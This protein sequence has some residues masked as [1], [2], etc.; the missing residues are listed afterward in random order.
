VSNIRDHGTNGGAE[1]GA[2]R[3][4][5]PIQWVLPALVCM[6]AALGAVAG[7][8]LAAS[9]P[10]DQHLGLVSG[11]A[12]LVLLAGAGV[13]AWITALHRRLARQ[14]TLHDT[15]MAHMTHGVSVIDKNLTVTAINA[16][17]MELL[18][19]PAEMGPGVPYEQL[20]QFNAERGEYGPGDPEE[21]I[22]ERMDMARLGE[23]I[24]FD[25]VRPN[26]QVLQIRG[27][28]IPGGGFVTIYTD[29]T[30]Q[31][32][33]DDELKAHTAHLQS[34]L[35]NL[36]AR[37]TLRDKGKR[38]VFAN[39]AYAE[40]FSQPAKSFIGKTTEEMFGIA[41]GV[42]VNDL[43]DEVIATG[44]AVR[45]RTFSA[46]RFPGRTFLADV[47]PL[48][49][50]AG[51]PLGFLTSHVDVSELH[52]TQRK[53]REKVE[54]LNTIF[55]NVPLAMSIRDRNA[56]II[57]MNEY[58]AKISGKRPADFVG[59]TLA[60]TL[61]LDGFTEPDKA[62]LQVS[63]TG[64]PVADREIVHT[65]DPSRTSIMRSIPLFDVDGEVDRVLNVMWE[66][67]EL[68]QAEREAT[69]RLNMLQSVIDNIPAVI[70]IRDRDTRALLINETA[71]KA[72]GMSSDEVL[73]K[74]MKE[75][76]G[77]KRNRTSESHVH[78][79]LETGEPVRNLEIPFAFLPGR[80]ALANYVPLFDNAGEVDGVLTV[81]MDITEKKDA[82]DHLRQAGK[83]STLGQMA[84]GMVHELSQPT[85]IIKLSA[86][87]SLLRIKRGKIDQEY[88][89]EQFSRI[90]K[91]A[92]RMGK[93]IDHIR[94]FSRK[95][96]SDF[97]LFDVIELIDR[98][99][100]LFRVQLKSTNIALSCSQIP[101]EV[102]CEGHPFQLEQ[103]LLNLLNNAKDAIEERSADASDAP[104]SGT[105][106]VST[107]IREGSHSVEIVVRDDGGGIPD[108][109]LENI[110]DPFFTTK[111]PGKGTGLGLSV[112]YGIVA[113]M[114][115]RISASRIDGGMVFTV[116]LPCSTTAEASPLSD[117]G[118]AIPADHLR[119]GRGRP[120]LVV[121]DEDE[122]ATMIQEHLMSCGFRVEVAENGIAALRKIE[123]ECPAILLT[124][125]KMP[126]MGGRELAGTV[127]ARFGDIPIIFITG[128]M[129]PLEAP[130]SEEI[131]KTITFL[132]KPVVLGELEDLVFEMIG[133]AAP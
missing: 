77:A 47:I 11:F 108:A 125:I 100:G 111:E 24:E 26:G 115:G 16:K 132:K 66:I 7:E 72:Y 15:M 35:D 65:V 43:V 58:G 55:D 124:D 51:N 23:P 69:A 28:P 63:R 36:P 17:A 96:T 121:D 1:T 131:D 123:R 8:A 128:E 9:S 113:N 119:D 80:I 59:H 70:S 56:R 87:G 44:V 22:R 83:L 29:V 4:T 52:K 129:V 101:S 40:S 117:Q 109:A 97:E 33:A 2:M 90:D 89:T 81:L 127:R 106:D 76:F 126:K 41:E 62:N 98:T 67:T 30:A 27:N 46:P 105:I 49:D 85:S 21:L 48:A 91:Q 68:K 92:S 95:E 6:L 3:R 45:S 34:I 73:G 118:E 116:V 10:L 38:F 130:D 25:R 114:S 94:L 5:R 74:T 78:H 107:Q 112:S 86:E 32:R 37:I 13:A 82:E 103:V 110:F 99:V 122:I 19:L 57:I 120:V 84:A 39:R 104:P 133:N 60:E 14:N 102:I 31:R 64:E 71:E 75:S 79:V 50:S 54:V 93:I 61:G 88:Q 53:L 20:L 18:D 12:A 42:T